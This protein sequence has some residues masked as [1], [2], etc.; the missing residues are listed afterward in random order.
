MRTILDSNVVLDL[1]QDN[2]LWAEW[3][4]RW[5]DEIRSTGGAVLNAVIYAEAAPETSSH[6]HF[7]S[8]LQ[9]MD[10]VF[11]DISYEAA[12]LAGHIHRQ[13]RQAGGIRVRVLPD[14]LIGAH[15]VTKGYRILTRDAARYRSYFPKLDIIAPDTHP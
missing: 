8:V 5:S 7:M 15:A 11:E 14:F 4:T 9:N 2:P 12:Y 1:L 10:V 13:Y 6:F 3:S